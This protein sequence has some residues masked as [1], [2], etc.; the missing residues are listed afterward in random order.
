MDK[1]LPE[2]KDQA[3]TP[4]VGNPPILLL[5]GTT[6]DDIVPVNPE[7]DP[8]L[9]REPE[10]Q[11]IQQAEKGKGQVTTH[12][13]SPTLDPQ[14]ASVRTHETLHGVADGELPHTERD[15]G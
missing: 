8:P 15:F 7:G 12:E 5:L 3:T 4:N 6:E 14:Q 10:T 13:L 1:G 9:N 2:G 11:V